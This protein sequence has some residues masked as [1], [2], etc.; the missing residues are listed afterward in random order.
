M[1]PDPDPLVIA[2]AAVAREG[3]TLAAWSAPGAP[4]P[5]ALAQAVLSDA[6]DWGRDGYEKRRDGDID[7]ERGGARAPTSPFLLL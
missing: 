3:A 6:V 5:A 1:P 4:V 7:R 2:Y